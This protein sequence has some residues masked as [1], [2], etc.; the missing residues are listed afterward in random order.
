MPD[1]SVR[2]AFI[3]LGA[4]HSRDQMARAVYEGVA[5][6]FRWILD[7]IR[8]EHGFGCPTLR[9]VGGRARARPGCAFWQ[10]SPDARWRERPTTRKPQPLA[11]L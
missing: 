3:N 6:N 9:A 2:A 11:Q 8:E 5:Y 4:N 1:E 7:L 10:M